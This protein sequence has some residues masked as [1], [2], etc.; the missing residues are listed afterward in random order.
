MRC[1]SSA[2]CNLAREQR[3]VLVRTDSYDVHVGCVCGRTG[4]CTWFL[5]LVTRCKHLVTRELS[6]HRNMGLEQLKWP[7]KRYWSVAIAISLTLCFL[8][9]RAPL[10]TT[11]L[12]VVLL[13]DFNPATMLK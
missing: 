6:K 10:L 8:F 11:S 13:S 12:V 2:D 4:C 9:L 3:A 5:L 1:F 7:Q